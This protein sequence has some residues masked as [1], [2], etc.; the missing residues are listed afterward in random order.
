MGVAEFTGKSSNLQDRNK[1]DKNRKHV[2]NSSWPKPNN[3]F[4]SGQPHT[5]CQSAPWQVQ[6]RSEVIEFPDF[7]CAGR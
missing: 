1:H 5:G 3:S 4:P 7:A 6:P 2:S